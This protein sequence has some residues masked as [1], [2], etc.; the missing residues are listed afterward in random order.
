MFTGLNISVQLKP[1]KGLEVSKI[2]YETVDLPLK[3]VNKDWV[4]IGKLSFSSF[5][6]CS[7]KES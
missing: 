6:I 3:T 4:N 2:M 1:F 7:Q 5:S